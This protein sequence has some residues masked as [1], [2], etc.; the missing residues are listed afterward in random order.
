MITA[1]RAAAQL[2]NANPVVHVE[3]ILDRDDMRRLRL[4]IESGRTVMTTVAERPAPTTDTPPRH[5]RGLAIAFA[6][7]VVV[8]AGVG[9]LLWFT[10]G[11]QSPADEAMALIEDYYDA[12]NAGETEGLLEIFDPAAAPLPIYNVEY[13]ITGLGEQIQGTCEPITE[14]EI[15][16][17][18]ECR[19][20]ITDELHSQA[21]LQ[22]ETL[23]I[24]KLNDDGTLTYRDGWEWQRNFEEAWDKRTPCEFDPTHCV[25][26]RTY[27]KYAGDYAEF[28]EAFSDWLAV[29]YPDLAAEVGKLNYRQGPASIDAVRSLIPL[30]DEYLAATGD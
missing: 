15:E 17:F 14:L 7:A 26:N 22:M 8:L 27:G 25:Q 10:G 13:W 30:V 23:T 21:G 16:G 18:I 11:S 3:D 5:R 29:A 24:Y 19:E 9:S 28:D 2:R 12:Y 20:V 6:A 4:Q 1:D